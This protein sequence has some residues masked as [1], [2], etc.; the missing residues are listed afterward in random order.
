MT[1]S[2][3]TRSL[4]RRTASEEQIQLAIRQL[5]SLVGIQHTVTDAAWFRG[6]GRRPSV[7]QD[8][9]DV[10]GVLPGG[11]AL[12][13]ECKSARGKLRPGQAERIAALRAA[14]AVVLVPRSVEEVAEFLLASGMTHPALKQLVDG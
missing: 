1:A 12:F 8:W 5:L 13:I 14:G 11:R 9:P 2:T 6:A 4:Y 10:S 7:D 3:S